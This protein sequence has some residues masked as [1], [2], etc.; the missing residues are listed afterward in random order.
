MR[1]A[2]GI[3]IYLVLLVLRACTIKVWPRS[4][5][6]QQSRQH[7]FAGSTVKA[8]LL[9]QHLSGEKTVSKYGNK[10]CKQG[11]GRLLG[12]VI[13]KTIM[14]YVKLVSFLL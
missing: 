8:A 5:S 3:K 9:L 4:I 12:S 14:V 7:I 2:L 13:H 6:K 10:L 1:S 11:G